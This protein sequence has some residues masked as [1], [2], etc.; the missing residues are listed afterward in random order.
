MKEN[1]RKISRISLGLWD[2]LYPLLMYYA[3]TILVM[4]AAQMIFGSGTESYA[5]CQIITSVIT[6]PVMYRSFYRSDKAVW[7]FGA[8]EAYFPG[9]QVEWGVPQ[10]ARME[11]ERTPQ[12]ARK[13][14]ERTSQSVRKKQ[15]TIQ[16][17]QAEKKNAQAQKRARV[18]N[19]AWIV[20]I[21]ALIGTG[22][23]NLILMS[24]LAEASAGFAQASSSFY[25][26]T[27]VLE[28]ISSA[29]LTPVLE[30]LVYR[31]IIFGRLKRMLGFVPAMLLSALIFAIMHFNLVQFVYAL[32]FGMVLV[33]FMEKT[34]HLYGAMLG[35]I[36]ANALA[37]IRTETGFLD[38]TVD[39]SVQAWLLSA[40]CLIAG[41]LLLGGY[42]SWRISR[43]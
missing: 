25:G 27:L 40:G 12:S 26:S 6:L 42:V 18:L 2:I 8:Q 29:L 9:G 41:V 22:L 11:Q 16:H 37:V 38:R 14:Q 24:P 33:V 34:G 28:L 36:T 3:V 17:V 32:L 23:N 15:K 10:S 5:L 35:H 4:F 19:A 7:P 39:G 20:C 30:E 1:N 21:A 31:G 43:E 13:E